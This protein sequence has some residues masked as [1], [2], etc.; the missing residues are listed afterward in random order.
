MFCV[1]CG[2]ICTPYDW[3]NK[4]YSFYM[5]AVVIIGGGCDLN[6]RTS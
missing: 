6:L 1:V 3:L 4:G 2:V 5:A